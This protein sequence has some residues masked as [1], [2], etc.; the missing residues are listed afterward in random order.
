MYTP[1]IFSPCPLHSLHTD[2]ICWTIPGAIRFSLTYIP[3]PLQFVQVWT[4]PCQWEMRNKI[5]KC[6]KQCFTVCVQDSWYNCTLGSVHYLQ[7]VP[8]WQI[9]S[10]ALNFFS[11]PVI[12]VPCRQSHYKIY[13]IIKSPLS[14]FFQM[15]SGWNIL[16]QYKKGKKTF[17]HDV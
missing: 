10:F 7:G 17:I 3:L 15:H 14:V 11:W 8:C 9:K 13:Q 12:H 2:W 1:D 4:A 16:V 5:V 6:W